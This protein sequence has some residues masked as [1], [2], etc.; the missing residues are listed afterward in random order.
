MTPAVVTYDLVV[1]CHEATLFGLAAPIIN[2]FRT[3]GYFN[4]SS[5]GPYNNEKPYW[6][7]ASAK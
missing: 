6:R 4:Q 7:L 5:P 3:E 2:T 1:P